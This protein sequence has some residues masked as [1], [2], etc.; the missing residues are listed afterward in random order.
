MVG[1]P[2]NTAQSKDLPEGSAPQQRALR[3]TQRRHPVSVCWRNGGVGPVSLCPPEG[4]GAGVN[5]S[6]VYPK[7]TLKLPSLTQVTGQLAEAGKAPGR[8]W[9]VGHRHGWGCGPV[10]ERGLNESTENSR[11]EGHCGPTSSQTHSGW[12]MLLARA[13]AQRPS[14]QPSYREVVSAQHCEGRRGLA[15]L[16]AGR[17]PAAQPGVSGGARAGHPAANWA[18]PGPRMLRGLCID[19]HQG[20]PWLWP[21]RAP[22]SPLSATAASDIRTGW[23]LNTLLFPCALIHVYFISD[24]IWHCLRENNCIYLSYFQ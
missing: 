20:A 11:A 5:S 23:P 6:T 18:R 9:A 15:P 7:G 8:E 10:R 12:K 4:G 2:L 14:P 13:A 16:P 22:A 17:A 19:K 1:P 21:S 24:E 3:L